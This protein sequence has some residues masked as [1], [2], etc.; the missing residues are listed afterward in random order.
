ME[1]IAIAGRRHGPRS[2]LRRNTAT[3]T[4]ISR[5][6]L[7]EEAHSI[8]LH[9]VSYFKNTYFQFDMYRLVMIYL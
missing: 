1:N 3:Q 5:D 2:A 6:I 9:V 8:D 4:E 7:F